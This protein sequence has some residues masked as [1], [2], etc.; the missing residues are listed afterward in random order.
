M[1]IVLDRDGVINYE[2]DDYIKSPEE[3]MPIPGSLPA[4]AALKKAGHIVVVATNQSGIGRGYYTEEILTQIHAKFRHLL[5]E[6][7]CDVDG[8][9]YCPHLPVDH[10]E[11]RK[12]KPGLFHQI[13]KQFNVGWSHAIA[14]GDALRDI[15]A[16][17]AVNCPC[18]LVRT[19][20]GKMTEEKGVGLDGVEIVD[21]L[22]QF[23]RSLLDGARKQPIL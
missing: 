17:Q 12:P 20:R 9:F 2:S 3:W 7:A 11:C 18:V 6:L 14:V 16:A 4:I 15:Q 22:A 19:G 5:S 21:D 23:V 10:C 13:G 8:I 1:L